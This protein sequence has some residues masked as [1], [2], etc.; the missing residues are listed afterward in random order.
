MPSFSADAT[1]RGRSMEKILAKKRTKKPTEKDYLDQMKVAKIS[2]T[3]AS[4]YNPPFY[5]YMFMVSCG[6]YEYRFPIAVKESVP[7][8]DR[9]RVARNILKKPPL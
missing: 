7:P 8:G 5:E 4:Q 3:L 2:D 6:T 9:D 1:G